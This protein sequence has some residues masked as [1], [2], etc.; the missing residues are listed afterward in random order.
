MRL[1]ESW[2]VH[3]NFLMLPLLPQNYSWEITTTGPKVNADETEIFITLIKDTT[4]FSF[5]KRLGFERFI[6]L[7]KRQRRSITVLVGLA[8]KIA[9]T[10]GKN[11]IT[12]VAV[13]IYNAEFP[14]KI[15]HKVTPIEKFTG[16]YS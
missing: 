9:T 3:N 10:E 14:E 11:S 15:S 12:D 16:T 7:D 13:R 4:L 1:V 6:A 8:H 2:N 5:A